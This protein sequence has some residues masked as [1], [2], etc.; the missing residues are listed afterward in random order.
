[1]AEVRDTPAYTPL[2]DFATENHTTGGSATDA[3]AVVI[4]PHGFADVLNGVWYDDALD[5]AAHVEVVSGFPDDTYRPK[6]GV[7][8]AQAV[9]MLWEMNGAPTGAT[10]HGFSDVPAGAWYEAAL[11]WALDNDIVMGFPDD[12][13]RPKNVVNRAQFSMMAWNAADGVDDSPAHGF[14]DV[15]PGAWYEAGVDWIDEFEIMTGFPDETYR[16]KNPLNRAQIVNALH[17]VALDQDAWTDPG[18]AP[19]TVYF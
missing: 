2:V 1:V 15:P 7:N 12:T 18:A 17:Q 10:Q 8:R 9:S 16:P 11:N 3:V 6:D 19:D 5:W 14:P 13:F 4:P